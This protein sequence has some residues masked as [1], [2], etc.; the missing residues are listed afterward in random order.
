LTLNKHD[1]MITKKF[2]YNV[3]KKA[4]EREIIREKTS[5][6]IKAENE[7]VKYIQQ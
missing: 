5:L 3:K 7:W 2:Y 1:D 4:V 6:K